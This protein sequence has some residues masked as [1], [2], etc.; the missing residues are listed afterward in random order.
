MG[1]GSGCN[2][3]TNERGG[4]GGGG[5]PHISRRTRTQN[6]RKL[7]TAVL[8]DKQQLER[9]SDQT[10]LRYIL[11]RRHTFLVIYTA[12]DAVLSLLLGK[13]KQ[14]FV[15]EIPTPVSFRVNNYARPPCPGT[16]RYLRNEI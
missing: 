5:R 14:N 8:P 15:S 1:P 12:A 13:N 16:T 10:S 11:I 7:F 9:A 6:R 2:S 4:A 3:N